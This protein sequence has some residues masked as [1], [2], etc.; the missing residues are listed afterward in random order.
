VQ[1]VLWDVD[2][3][4][5]R[6]KGARVSLNAFLR[7]L[8]SVADLTSELAYPTDAGGKTDEQLAL[9]VLLAAAVDEQA[10][11]GLL[12]GFRSEYLRR[13]ETEVEQLRADLRVL[14]GVR[15]ALQALH[16]AGIRQSLLTGNLE[17]IARLKLTCVGL[18]HYFA[19]EVGA[20]G[21]DH[22]DRTR[23]VPV[24]RERAAAGLGGAPEQVVVIGD[25]PRDIACARAGGA[26]AIAVATG[27]Y[28]LDDLRPHAPDALLEDLRDT[29]AVLAAVS[30]TVHQERAPIV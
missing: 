20:Y 1:L 29:Q 5:V 16:A 12:P 8:S 10:A 26:R 18:E 24:A 2:G 28:S 17:P 9:E 25:T 6:T 14:P 23:L 11:R 15:E 3:T 22:A 13:L 7:A 27:N 21:S 4:L 19:F 30:G